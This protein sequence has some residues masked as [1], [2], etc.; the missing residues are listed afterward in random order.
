MKIDHMQ[1]Y[2]GAIFGEC[3]IGGPTLKYVTNIIQSYLDKDV[4]IERHHNVF[5]VVKHKLNAIDRFLCSLRLLTDPH[6]Y[7]RISNDIVYEHYHHNHIKF[8]KLPF[9]QLMFLDKLVTML[10]RSDIAEYADLILMEMKQTL[11][12]PCLTLVDSHR[13]LNRFT[14]KVITHIIPRRHGKTTFTNYLN[15]L[16]LVFF[17][18]ANLRM[19]YVAQKKDLTENAFKTIQVL[20]EQLSERFNYQQKNFYEY[21]QKINNNNNENNGNEYEDFY[22]TVIPSFTVHS[23]SVLCNFY[24]MSHKSAMCKE[25]SMG[26]NELSCMVYR[27]RN[28]SDKYYIYFFLIFLNHY[29]TSII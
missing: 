6:W 7:T 21:R 18:C 1:P 23:N 20:L 19:L 29:Q 5:N 24:K 14:K 13:L 17:P 10:L 15:A 4:I 28:V 12:L 22:Y 16:C 9:Q 25:R 26:R 8:H 2:H 11:S 27:E 3:Q